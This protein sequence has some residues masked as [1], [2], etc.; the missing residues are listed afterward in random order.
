MTECFLGVISSAASASLSPHMAAVARGAWPAGVRAT[1]LP[2][3][4]GTASGLSGPELPTPG[5]GSSLNPLVETFVPTGLERGG[6]AV[7]EAGAGGAQGWRPGP[8]LLIISS[9]V[10]RWALGHM[11]RE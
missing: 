10:T 2:S 5:C 9:E 7:G 4:S 8:V 6:N 1:A 11:A 3:V